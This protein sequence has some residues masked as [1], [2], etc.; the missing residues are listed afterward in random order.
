MQGTIRAPVV[1]SLASDRRM[2][3]L[4][5][6]DEAPQ[7][8]SVYGG[9]SRY[10]PNVSIWSKTRLSN[11]FNK[12][13]IIIIGVLGRVSNEAISAVQKINSPELK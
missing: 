11:L 4:R 10:F 6:A 12:S 7:W 13:I 8:F 5:S 2:D 9:L 1:P 3:R